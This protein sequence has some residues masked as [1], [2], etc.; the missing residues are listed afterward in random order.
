MTDIDKIIAEIDKL[1]GLY[2]KDTEVITDPDEMAEL[3]NIMF[4][5]D[6]AKAIAKGDTAEQLY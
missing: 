3:A 1:R 4:G 6:Q 2:E 5:L